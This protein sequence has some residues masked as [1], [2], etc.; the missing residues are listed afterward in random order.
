MGF[1]ALMSLTVKPL[2]KDTRHKDILG[3]KD[4]ISDLN[5]FPQEIKINLL[6]KDILRNFSSKILILKEFYQS[7]PNANPLKLY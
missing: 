1:V 2:Y 3:N 6:T 7:I 4:A 5:D